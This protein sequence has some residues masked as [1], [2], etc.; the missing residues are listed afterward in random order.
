MLENKID[1]FYNEFFILINY[2]IECVRTDKINVVYISR[3]GNLIKYGQYD[4]DWKIEK[5]TIDMISDEDLKKLYNFL[6]NVFADDF[7]DGYKHV[8]GKGWSLYP[9]VCNK[10]LLEISSDNYNDLNWIIEEIENEQNNFSR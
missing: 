5:N 3:E 7:I 10:I 6:K 9:M 1:K 4:N 2:I 8:L